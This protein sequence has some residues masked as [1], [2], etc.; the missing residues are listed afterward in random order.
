[1][2]ISMP[3]MGGIEAISVLSK[4]MPDIKLLPLTMHEEREYI[5][6]ILPPPSLTAMVGDS[7]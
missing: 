6:D 7:R 1:M 3:V 4:E 2:D 5:L